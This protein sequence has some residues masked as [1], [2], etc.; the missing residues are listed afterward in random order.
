MREAVIQDEIRKELGNP[1]KYPEIILW[2]NNSG[3][4]I[5]QHGRRVVFGIGSPG[6]ADLIGLFAGRFIALE[7]KSATGQQTEEQRRFEHLVTSKGGVYT[8]L[9]SVE[10]A[11]AFVE[12]MRR[13]QP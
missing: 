2:R 1:T 13:G 12:R 3:Q 6:G 11:V 4:M 7:I 5:D 8:V 10:E 9:R